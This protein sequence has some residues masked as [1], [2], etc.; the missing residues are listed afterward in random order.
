MAE[1]QMDIDKLVAAHRLSV[2]AA[3][4][5]FIGACTHIYVA[6]AVIPFHL[7]C[8]FRIGRIV[9]LNTI[10]L[11]AIL[12]LMLVPVVNTLALL[13]LNNKAFRV[14]KLAGV[15]IGFMGFER[16]NAQSTNYCLEML[17]AAKAKE[18]GGNSVNQEQDQRNSAP[19]Q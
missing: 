6:L 13:L 5:G 11:I 7:Y 2:W 12:V 9:R 4:S 17:K 3:V 10:A 1:S 19:R 14:L 16:E 15:P 18:A 8:A